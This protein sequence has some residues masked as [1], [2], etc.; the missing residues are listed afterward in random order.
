M[1]LMLG[2]LLEV[3]GSAF[4]GLC[5]LGA[6]LRLGG[7]TELGE[8]CLIEHVAFGLPLA[9]RYPY[10]TIRS[11]WGK[12]LQIGS[13]T[14]RYVVIR[15]SASTRYGREGVNTT[16]LARVGGHDGF[17]EE[18]STRTSGKLVVNV[19]TY[20]GVYSSPG[21]AA[22]FIW[23]MVFGGVVISAL[24]AESLFTLPWWELLFF[25]GAIGI[26]HLCS[27]LVLAF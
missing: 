20:E 22:V 13:I 27:M 9:R 8:D 12:I 25:S 21:F 26:L 4:S 7:Y 16:R 17:L 10:D 19:L 5:I 15:W 3:F 11:V 1:A 14:F 23:A 24:L 6:A 2:L 18:L